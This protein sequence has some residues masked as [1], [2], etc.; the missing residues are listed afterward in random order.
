MAQAPIRVLRGQA[1][2]LPPHESPPVDR[3]HVVGVCLGELGGPGGGGRPVVGGETVEGF[4]VVLASDPHGLTVVNA[5]CLGK[6]HR[7][8]VGC[9]ESLQERGQVVNPPRRVIRRRSPAG[10]RCG[11]HQRSGDPETDPAGRGR[12]SLPPGGR[13]RRERHR[14]RRRG[15]RCSGRSPPQQFR[16][17]AGWRWRWTGR[18]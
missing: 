16:R 1:V 14:T 12:R 5:G 11:G 4:V 10:H 15:R 18:R 8:G 13:R 3:C 7:I 9:S 2:N 6:D 17:S